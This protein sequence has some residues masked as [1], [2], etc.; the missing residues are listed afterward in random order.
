MRRPQM[1]RQRCEDLIK[2]CVQQRDLARFLKDRASEETQQ[3]RLHSLYTILER[4]GPS[5]PVKADE[6]VVVTAQ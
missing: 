2:D 6:A 3:N 4:F 1:S 5:V